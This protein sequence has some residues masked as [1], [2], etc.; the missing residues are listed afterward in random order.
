MNVYW[1]ALSAEVR[2]LRRTLALWLALIIPMVVG[3]LQFSII[4]FRGESF[5]Q[6]V[7]NPMV[8]FGRQ[9]IFFWCLLVLPLFITLE[10]A[11]LAGVEHSSRGFKHL[12]ALP[13]PRFSVYLAKQTAALA[14]LVISFLSLTGFI[15]LFEVVLALAKPHLGFTFALPI[16][17][18]LK[19]GAVALTGSLLI[20]AVHT[21]VGLWWRSFVVAVAFGI[22]VT[23]AGLIIINADWGR[24]YPW[25]L[26]ALSLNSFQKGEPIATG[27]MISV[28]GFIMV[29]LIGGIFFIRRDV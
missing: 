24:Y 27:L 11:L 2:K 19:Y 4:I 3:A 21:W 7:E 5:L 10:T 6:N 29:L 13:L 1:R 18:F 14:L 28:A 16:G 26:P 12:F 8:W 22:S 17:I 25:T 20:L 23:V 9:T 15:L